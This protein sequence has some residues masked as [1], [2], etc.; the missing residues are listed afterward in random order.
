MEKRRAVIA[1]KKA[2]QDVTEK[3][4]LQ[5]RDREDD[6]AKTLLKK[7]TV[8][9]K[10]D[11]KI[12]NGQLQT[13]DDTMKK[14][15]VVVEIERKPVNVKKPPSKDKVSTNAGRP[16]PKTTPSSQMPLP[17]TSFVKTTKQ[18]IS[19]LNSGPSQSELKTSMPAS[20]SKLQASQSKSKLKEV[21]YDDIRQPSETLQAQ[22]HARIQAQIAQAKQ[23]ESQEPPIPSESIELPDINSEYVTFSPIFRTS[24]NITDIDIQ[25]RTMKIDL[26]PSTRQT[27]LNHLYWLKLCS[28]KAD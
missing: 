19:A 2:E 8:L 24:A 14:R 4:K 23:R 5:K 7:V 13:D 18:A 16:P 27:G 12:A 22:M 6:T 15:K 3:S 28:H 11:V 21:V 9:C 1:S 25:I 20:S 26:E 17:P 10:S